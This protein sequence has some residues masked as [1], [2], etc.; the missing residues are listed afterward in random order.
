MGPSPH[1]GEKGLFLLQNR[2]DV[3]CPC[4]D[5]F[6]TLQPCPHSC[7]LRPEPSDSTAEKGHP[8]RAPEDAVPG[9]YAQ[10]PP[11]PWHA[12]GPG[13][14]AGFPWPHDPP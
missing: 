12:Q 2:P 3:T 9:P 4:R 13:P 11:A 14:S 6:P 10:T 5:W 1:S 7:A 8:R